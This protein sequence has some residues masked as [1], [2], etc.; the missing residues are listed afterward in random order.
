MS[1]T[2]QNYKFKV[3]LLGEGRVG[4]TSLVLRY[5]QN[6]F[7][8]NQASTLQA[9]YLEKRINLG[10]TSVTLSIWDTA[11]QERFH[12]L[13]PIYYRDANGAVL[14][15][16]ITDK[17]SFLK[18]QNWVEELRKVVG[19][20]IVLV[21][22]SNKD[23]LAAKRQVSIE[24]ASNYAEKVGAKVFPTSAKTNKGVEEIFLELTKLL[25]KQQKEKEINNSSSPRNGLRGPKAGIAVVD[26]TEEKRKKTTCCQLL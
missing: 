15:Y 13:A 19:F 21:M 11:G 25:L 4:K 7:V 26:D 18:V 9:S 23:D 8:E 17:T 16:D 6:T 20:D 22:A 14:V 5:V 1:Q 24:E 10:S 3:V 2:I 12:A